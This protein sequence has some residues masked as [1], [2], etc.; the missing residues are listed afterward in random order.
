MAMTEVA[1]IAFSGWSTRKA[2]RHS[3]RCRRCPTAMSEVTYPTGIGQRTNH[4]TSAFLG[5]AQFVHHHL[6]WCLVAAYAIAAVFPSPGLA[7]RNMSIAD[8][9]VFQNSIHVSPLLL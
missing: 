4:V 8:L 6:L 9:S 1:A 5:M 3:D 2:G 7:I